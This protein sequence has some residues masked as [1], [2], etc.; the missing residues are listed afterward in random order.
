[1]TVNYWHPPYFGLRWDCDEAVGDE[2]DRDAVPGGVPLLTD[3]RRARPSP[4]VT[5]GAEPQR[6]K[7]PPTSQSPVLIA[8]P[9]TSP[10][11]GSQAS[12]GQDY[13]QTPSAP[14]TIWAVPDALQ[15][16]LQ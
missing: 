14:S 1:W 4:S 10:D 6:P 13:Q 7:D 12:A 15:E 16:P 8:T 2:L 11:I 5:S 9:G 3:D